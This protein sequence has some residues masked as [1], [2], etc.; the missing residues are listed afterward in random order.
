[1]LP[2][3]KRVGV[4]GAGIMGAQLAALFAG[5][6]CE[7]E[8]LDV[9]PGD[10]G[11]SDDARS[12]DRLAAT[13]VSR[14]PRMKPA[15]LYSRKDALLIRPGNMEDHLGRLADC[16][17]VV[18]AVVERAEIKRQIFA[19]LGDVVSKD[20]VVSSNTSGFLRKALVEGMSPVMRRRFLV[21]HF[22]NPP[23]YMKLLEVVSGDA[24][25]EATGSIALFAEERLGKG[26]VHAKDTPLFVA[27]RIGVFYVLDIMHSIQEEG[28][29]IEAVDAVLSKPTARPRS[30][31]FRTVDMAGVD[32][33]TY[34]AAELV[35]GCPNDADTGRCRI[36]QYLQQM[37]VRGCIGDKSGHG[38][39]RKDK[40]TGRILALD[41]NTLEYRPRVNFST[42]S[43]LEA[44]RTTDP[45]E[46]LRRVVF[47]KDQAGEIAWPVISSAICYAA[48]R[49]PEI[50]DD[51][52]PVDC[53]M[54][55]GYNWELGPFET[56]DALGVRKVADRLEDEGR[57]VP[58]LVEAMLRA[59]HTHF[60]EWRAHHR[61]VLD[62]AK[63]RHRAIP[64]SEKR[65][66]LGRLK[67]VGRLVERNAGASL[68]DAGDGVFAL[69][70][71]TKMNSIDDDVLE[72]LGLALDRVDAEGEGLL[73]ANEGEHFCAG[74][75]LMLILMA[76]KQKRWDAIETMVRVFQSANQRIRFFAKPVMAVP[77]GMT[78]GGGCEI[79]LSC[80]GRTASIESYVGLVE[81]GAGLVPAGGGCKNLI[82][83]MEN[84]KAGGPQPKVS[85]AFE[86][87]ATARVSASAR[88]AVEM[89]LLAK[90]DR[91]AMD[92]ETQLCEARL[93]ILKLAKNYSPPAMRTNILLPGRGGEMALA[94]A[95]RGLVASGR[96][97]EYDAFV[98]GK[99]ARV[100]SG[101]DNPVLHEATEDHILDLERE[102]FLSL[103][104]EEKSQARMAA[105][106]ESGKP[107]RN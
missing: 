36:P 68:V 90:G 95:A 97:T 32:T 92:R 96:A 3:I 87:I 54:R 58:A 72:M 13:A 62:V 11:P 76:A 52:A 1:M 91:I 93:E 27:N 86:L 61:M 28:W 24:D 47:A 67:E 64:G 80:A 43:L 98:A 81:V 85:A 34:V 65:V 59:G 48:N 10:L 20:A 45:A 23:R 84:A 89:G 105:L 60:Y 101:G 8:L 44:A 57:A 82:L 79:C 35:K 14:L 75:N 50:A 66:T 37:V 39:Y 31:V 55:W 38:F 46:R 70:F 30:G 103:V 53:A 94:N 77:F 99:L 4:I 7:V 107:L 71:H 15:P 56:W 102:A 42:P 83:A 40:E 19:M 100:L 41:P 33:L 2:D 6:G 9:V 21:T 104:G 26:V 16:S 12:R 78:I 29:P 25:V 17:W 88:E 63:N 18:E 74:A 49:I 73:I 22:F 106:L 69:E 51:P 5:A